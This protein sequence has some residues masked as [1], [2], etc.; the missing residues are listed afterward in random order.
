MIKLY[1]D[2]EFTGLHPGTTLMSIGIVSD[3][4]DSFYAELTDYDYSQVDNW[5]QENVVDNFILDIPNTPG[6]LVTFNADDGVLRISL[7]G[8]TD[9]ITVAL[10]KWLEHIAGG[11]A[12]QD[13]LKPVKLNGDPVFELWSDVMHYDMVLLHNLWG[14]AFKVPSCLYYIPCDLATLM[15]CNGVNPDTN[16][17]GFAYGGNVPPH[18]IKHNA[19]WDAETIKLCCDK[20]CIPDHVAEVNYDV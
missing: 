16:R 15:R 20:L 3:N 13:T 2:T 14:H 10:E 9:T 7:K 5:I 6:E 1:F 12:Y 8:D 17:E 18:G 19:L 11:R 4:G